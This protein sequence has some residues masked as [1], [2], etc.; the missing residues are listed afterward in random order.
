MLKSIADLLCTAAQ[1]RRN[2]TR[3]QP[4]TVTQRNTLPLEGRQPLGGG[5]QFGRVTLC[6]GHGV[7][8]VGV[9]VIVGNTDCREISFRT[10]VMAKP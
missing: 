1:P 9:R 7:V 2:L 3:L 5:M 4:I 6:V 8:V 10:A